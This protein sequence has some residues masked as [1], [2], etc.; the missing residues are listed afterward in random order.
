MVEQAS[1]HVERTVSAISTIKAF[2]AQQHEAAR[3]QALLVR[4]RQV[5][6][7]STLIWSG[8]FGLTALFTFSMFVQ[9]FWYG[10]SLV[11]NGTLSPGDVMT[12]FW[13]ALMA[14]TRIGSL[15]Q[16]AGTL[17]RGQ[18]AL[19]SIQ[20]WF[21]REPGSYDPASSAS[22]RVDAG[23]ARTQSTVE[24]SNT[25]SA[26]GG[27]FNPTLCLGNIVFHDVSF[28]YPTR[29]ESLALDSCTIRILA[30]QTTYLVG[31]SGSG[32]STIANLV[33]GLYS[34]E[35]GCVSLD[36]RHIWS[37][38]TQFLRSNIAA[39]TQVPVVFSMT[40]RDNIALG[41]CTN[42]LGG[43]ASKIR[44]IPQDLIEAAARVAL[45]HD[46]VKDLP[47]EYDTPVGSGGV[48]LSGGQRQRLALARAVLCNP[49][50]LILDE[51]TS[52]LDVA[53]R[54]LVHTAL[55]RSRQGRT[56]L[57][58]THDMSQVE[59]EANIYVLEQGKVVE[60][61]EWDELVAIPD[62][63]C[64]RIVS[65]AVQDAPP[66]PVSITP[67][68]LLSSF[69]SL[70]E[71]DD[72]GDLGHDA[73][74]HDVGV[75]SQS[76]GMAVGQFQ[77]GNAI[78]RE[79]LWIKA[80]PPRRQAISPP[81][82]ICVDSRN[83]DTALPSDVQY[84]V[85][86]NAGSSSRSRRSFAALR[87][88]RELVSTIPTVYAHGANMNASQARPSTLTQSPSALQTKDTFVWGSIKL[89]IRQVPNRPLLCLGFFVTVVD[90]FAAPSFSVILGRLMAAMGSGRPIAHSMILSM[91]MVLLGLAIARG[92][93]TFGRYMLLE[94]AA[95]EWVNA[96][97]LQA[98][99]AILAQHKSWFDTS[100]LA[101]SQ[102]ITS[103]IAKDAEDARKL[104]AF[105]LGELLSS[106]AL[107]VGS[108]A[109]SFAFGWE[110]TLVGLGFGLLFVVLLG[111]NS[112]VLA[113]S[114]ARNKHLREECANG[115][116]LLVSHVRAI[117]SM[118]LE[119]VFG[120]LFNQAVVAAHKDAVR[121]APANGFGGGAAEGLQYL[122]EAGIYGVASFFLA[123]GTYQL[124]Q[125]TT[126][127]NVLIFA[128]SF[129]GQGAM[130]IPLLSKCA[131]AHIDLERLSS[132]PLDAGPEAQGE[133]TPANL[134]GCVELR[135][136]HFSYPAVPHSPVLTGV[137]LR[138]EPGESVAIVGASGCG[139]STL[140]ALLQRLYEPTGGSICF[141][142]TRANAIAV[143]FL[144]DKLAV[145]SQS[146]DLFP[147]TI[148]ANIAY[149]SGHLEPSGEGWAMVPAT[150]SELVEATKGALVLDFTSALPAGLKTVVGE[151]QAALSGGQ[152][153][154]VA[155]AR[156]LARAEAKVRVLDECTAALDPHTQL[157]VLDTVLPQSTAT[158][159]GETIPTTVVV[160]HKINIMRR[161]D[162]VVV[163][164]QGAIAEEGP[165]DT[166]LS[167]N[168]AL[169]QLVGSTKT[170]G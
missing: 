71:E 90:G 60:H 86:L 3:F 167:R 159:P 134:R 57:V 120:T 143:N 148:E 8:R 61:G 161:C 149:G 27:T 74:P 133:L 56:T 114:E 13:A 97:R 108:L 139:K 115:L 47:Q 69:L 122:A 20:V 125:V 98:Y 100:T 12:V 81:N 51:A 39:V 59:G 76:L 10:T 23:R 77:P 34:P 17:H 104:I 92:L 109:V 25:P 83:G 116:F 119:P 95:D 68:V 50:V 30:G 89:A 87:R 164:H 15:L 155:L 147:G 166:L 132:L 130:Y 1:G 33:L 29:P 31:G 156:M 65:A 121:A 93:S 42:T 66:S 101:S 154:R 67:N 144:R 91:S 26:F 105:A 16:V 14:S 113:R 88:R 141:D 41:A 123:R 36:G 162:R 168:G 2:N 160:T 96:R 136:V 53:S 84:D 124:T 62:G 131:R 79:S 157:G 169:A 103:C 107:M 94:A 73:T 38:P 142:G 129:A 163:L 158:K 24:H 6:L 126:T 4:A 49:S 151:R 58:I 137:S 54:S 63:V 102:R 150:E 43:D 112:Q 7:R 165:Y 40:I 70:E 5:Y 128:V 152:A 44:E 85:L 45:L 78:N 118:A 55:A 82:H 72:E 19:K 11:K 135:D 21:K 110:L 127:L 52:A 111:W 35:Q 170:E 146:P 48:A 106:G 153:Q 32:K 46:Y 64:A 145:V 117:R 18:V 80:N 75:W 22:S 37:L 9:G 28:R 138:I 140:A 99:R